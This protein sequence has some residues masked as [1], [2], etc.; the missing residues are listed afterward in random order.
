MRRGPEV[1]VWRFMKVSWK[2][3]H[4][5]VL[6]QFLLKNCTVKMDK[7]LIFFYI[8]LILAEI[9]QVWVVLVHKG[10]NNSGPYLNSFLFKIEH[11]KCLKS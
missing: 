8:S 5:T 10:V 6:N 9:L 3:Q 11:E 1:G 7:K 2:D 4:G